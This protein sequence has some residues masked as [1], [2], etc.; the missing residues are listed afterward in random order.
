MRGLARAVVGLLQTGIDF[1]WRLGK[2][3]AA[4]EFSAGARLF[5]SVDV[6]RDDHHHA[7]S[8][9]DAAAGKQQPDRNATADGHHSAAQSAQVS[10]KRPA[11]T[12][13]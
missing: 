4:R 12:W 1:T 10:R 11:L 7:A 3:A 8:G 2:L 9:F 5:G 6:A 13:S